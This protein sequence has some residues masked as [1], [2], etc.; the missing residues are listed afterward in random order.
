MKRTVLL[1][2]T[3][4][5]SLSVLASCGGQEGSS[6]ESVPASSSLDQGGASE[7]KSS[8]EENS[9]E[10]TLTYTFYFDLNGGSSASY[11]EQ[12]EVTSLSASDFFFD[13]R[14]SGYNFRGWSYNGIK[15][16]DEKG[17]ELFH[18]TMAPLMTFVAVYANDAKMSIRMN[19]GEAGTVS[20]EGYYE[21]NTDVNVLATPYQGYEFVGWYDEDDIALSNQASYKYRMSDQDITIEAR[22]KLATFKLDI[23]SNNASLGVVY[24]NPKSTTTTRQYGVSDSS[25]I[26]YTSEV[27]VAAYTKTDDIRFLGWFNESDELVSTNAVYSFS[28]PNHDYVLEAKWN[29]FSITYDLGGGTNGDSNPSSVSTEDQVSLSSPTRDGYNFKGWY[30]KATDE[31]VTSISAGT[32]N[33]IELYAKWEA[34]E[35]AIKY[36][37][38]EN[39]VN[40]P[41]NPSTYTIEESVS[42]SDPT[43]PGYKFEGWYS[44]SSFNNVCSSISKGSTGAKTFYAKWM[45]VEY[46]IA[47]NLDGGTNNIDNPSTFTVDD[48]VILKDPAKAGYEFKGWYADSSYLTKV[49]GI[50]EGSTGDRELFAKWEAIKH[51]LTVLSSDEGRGTATKTSGEGYTDETM[52]VTAV[53][54]GG[55]PFVG[56]YDGDGNL[57]SEENPYSFAMPTHDFTV[58]ARFMTKAEEER[59]KALGIDPVIDLT[60]NTLTYGLYPQTR[61]SK[62]STISSLNALKSAESNGWYL[63]DGSYYAKKSASPYRSSYTFDDGTTIVEGTTYWFKCEPITWKILSSKNGEHSLVSTVLLDTYRYCGFTKAHNPNSYS[64]SSIR[65]WLNGDFYNSAF[66]LGDSNILETTV[67]N[68]ASTTSSKPN[69]YAGANTDDKVYLLS[70]KDYL[71]ADYGFST[72]SGLSTTRQCK[73]TDWARANGAWCSTDS[74]YLYNG[75]YWTRSPDSSDSLGALRVEPEG[76]FSS[77]YVDYSFHSVRPAITIKIA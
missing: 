35:F 50:S 43:R 46:T 13:C 24:I 19:M 26:T 10:E 69:G 30:D 55:S 44:D 70:Y 66:S 76:D 6:A 9:S 1:C 56:W 33:D 52:A 20:G 74:S 68:S 75:W 48:S 34:I 58:E 54:I 77:G 11:K 23:N 51:T 2:A 47:Y 25:S 27:K 67:N 62:E 22:F 71:N 60:N 16:F 42:L 14:K 64:L 3:L 49:A 38:G 18:P 12:Q 57:L 32:L 59:R 4:V 72:F 21:Y 8:L 41:G 17:N 36:V 53:S 40:A 5:A 73:T 29:S 37:L 31:R 65:K 28:M 39:G 61:V 15:V 63:L 7:S 45:V